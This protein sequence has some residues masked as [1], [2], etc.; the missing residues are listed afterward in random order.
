MMRGVIPESVTQ[1]SLLT[2]NFD[3]DTHLFIH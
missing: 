2:L 3:A 1:A